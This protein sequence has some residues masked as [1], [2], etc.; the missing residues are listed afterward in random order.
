M[1]EIIG[2]ATYASGEQQTFTDSNAFIK[3]IQ[4]ELSYRSTSGFAYK[5]LTTDA[6]TRKAVDDLVYNE[7]GEE[8]PHDLA[9]YQSTKGETAQMT[10]EELN[11]ALY[12]KMFAEQETYRGW[13]LTQPP[14][15]ILKHTYE[16]TVREDILMSLENN[17]LTDIQAAALLQSPS[18]LDD[19]FQ[20][21][22]KLETGY[23]DTVLDCMTDRANALVQREQEAKT[24]LLELPVY[25]YPADYAREHG[26]LEQYRASHKANIACRDAIDTAIAEHYRDN[27][28]GNSAVK[29]VVDAFGYDRTLYVLANTVRQKDWDGRIS[30]DNKA[31]A[32]TIPVYE[33]KDHWGSDRCCEFVV[34][35]AHPGLVNLFVTQ[36]R[37]EYLLTQ[38]LTKEDIQ[39]E[40]ARLLGRLQEP[41]QPNSPNGTHYMAQISQ[42]FLLRAGTKEQDKLFDMLPFQS[43]TV[44]G[45]KDRKGLF[46]TISKDEN[47]SQP[48]RQR[49]PSVRKKLEQT[50]GEPKPPAPKKRGLER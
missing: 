3:T 5:I 14:D 9:Y 32:K 8:N 23:M 12:Q 37:H 41:S 20:E 35:R 44:S 24:A 29:Q 22:E 45:M 40:A 46:A 28:L 16:Y 49:K 18:P 2:I 13:L 30:H 47:R 42:D 50:T 15:E 48:L 33:D 31:W 21:F 36:A 38:P 39:Q 43:L 4:E 11:T 34:D 19:I 7:Y 27:C 1:S 17:D 26:E 10:S 25:S 6:A